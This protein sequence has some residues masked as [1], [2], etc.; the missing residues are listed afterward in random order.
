VFTERYTI[1]SSV[2]LAALT[3]YRLAAFELGHQLDFLFRN[4]LKYL[5][6]YDAIFIRALTDPLNA[7]YIVARLAEMQGLR[8]IDD[9]T[10]IRICC[11]KVNMYKRLINHNVP[12]PKTIFLDI[13]EVNKENA[14][15]LFESLGF[16]LVL[17]APNSSFSQYVDKVNSIDNFIKIGKKFLRRAD[18]IVVQQYIPSEYDWRVVTLN[19]KVLAVVKYIFAEN[20]W[21]LMDRS[22]DGEDSKAIGFDLKEANPA[23]L[24]VALQASEA[25]GKSLYGV[26]IKEVDGEYFVIEVND[27]PN[28]D[29]GS[30][31]QQ[32]PDIYRNIVRYL[33]GEDFA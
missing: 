27:N 20:T 24:Q 32:N 2:E 13:K 8:V 30:E 26:D 6:N 4:E 23:L 12:I 28:I 33:A 22:A 1:R 9:P 3:N 31:D 16:P 15:E 5:G 19:G 25:I 10:S 7:S 14:S 17:K 11:D 18:R 29:A 21:R